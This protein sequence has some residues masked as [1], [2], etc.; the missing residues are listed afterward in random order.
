MNHAPRKLLAGLYAITDDSITDPER[1]IQCVEQ[2]LSGGARII[3]FRDKSTLPDPRLYLCTAIRKLTRQAN[4]IFIVNDD[5]ELA[6]Q[7]NADGVHLGKEDINL[8]DARKQLGQG[9]LIGISCYNQFE[10]AEDAANQG[11]DYVAFGSFFSS[12]TK[13]GAVKA[14]IH[15]LQ[16][17]RQELD[18][19]VVA[20]GGITIENGRSLI[21]AG[22]DMLAVIDGLFG[23]AD[24]E[25]TARRFTSLF[26]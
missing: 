6:K 22:A 4:A 1:M 2:A 10:R 16:K 13:P 17:A 12:T 20:I 15:L 7:V 25:A 5:V 18:I 23:Q 19:P 11:A 3:Q 21:K 8:P 14:D 9:R 24:I 26:E